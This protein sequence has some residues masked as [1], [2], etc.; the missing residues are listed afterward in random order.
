MLRRHFR[1]VHPKDSVIVLWEGPFP[2]F[3]QCAMQCNRRYPRHIHSQVCRQGADRCTQRDSTIKSA[4]A[5]RQLFY[6]KED[7][8]EKV[9]SYCYLG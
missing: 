9:Q 5:L 1:D 8:L 6:V 2:Q 3:E 4:L 7:V